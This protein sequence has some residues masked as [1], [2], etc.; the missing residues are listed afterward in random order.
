MGTPSR[1]ASPFLT[2]FPVKLLP[3]ALCGAFFLQSSNRLQ[4]WV[5]RVTS[6]LKL[7]NFKPN[8]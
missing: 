6:Y 8:M 4:A 1:G 2:M 7:E 5:F 3:V